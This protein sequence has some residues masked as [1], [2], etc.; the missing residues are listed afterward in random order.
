M[1]LGTGTDLQAQADTER[2]A[3]SC[4]RSAAIEGDLH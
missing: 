4:I 2:K 1:S 3:G